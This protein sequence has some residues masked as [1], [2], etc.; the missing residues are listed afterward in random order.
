[1]A[2]HL[3]EAWPDSSINNQVAVPRPG[4]VIWLLSTSPLYSLLF[5]QSNHS[6]FFAFLQPA[7]LFPDP[8]LSDIWLPVPE[9][10][11][12]FSYSSTSET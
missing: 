4:L 11:L 3:L 5:V 9:G 7:K 10:T 2:E 6:N 8:G 1:M 12:P